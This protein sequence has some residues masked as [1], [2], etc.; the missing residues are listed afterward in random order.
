MAVFLHQSTCAW[1]RLILSACP[2]TTTIS[3]R[4]GTQM[5]DG[6]SCGLLEKAAPSIQTCWQVKPEAHEKK[7]RGFISDVERGLSPVEHR[8]S[9][10]TRL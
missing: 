9:R 10:C 3:L 1:V 5:H 8:Q 2:E 4:I 7:E 6:K